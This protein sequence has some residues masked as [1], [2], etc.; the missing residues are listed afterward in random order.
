MDKATQEVNVKRLLMF[1]ALAASLAL[2][3]CGGGGNDSS[4]SSTP[5]S[6]GTTVAVKS[7]DRMNVLVDSDGKA[8]YASDVEASGK[9]MCTTG[10]CTAFWKPLTTDSAK[11]T[12]VSNAGKIGVVKRPDGNMQVAIAGRP[13]YT[14][15][16]DSPGK[17]SGDGFS[18]DFDGRH[19]TWHTVLAGGKIS[20]GG[21]SSGSESGD[22]QA[23]P[24]GNGD[25]GY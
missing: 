21:S 3:A 10:A 8:L 2:A 15:S 19:F 24:S 9:V 23:A 12:A 6:S 4:G 14:F 20:A 25:Y 17:V 16:E 18:D 22:G 13:V 7:I 1:G 11:P 5:A